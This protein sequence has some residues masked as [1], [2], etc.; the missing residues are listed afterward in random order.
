M[1][2]V[3]RSGFQCFRFIS[4]EPS[5]IGIVPHLPPLMT[6]SAHFTLN[7][8]LFSIC[9]KYLSPVLWLSDSITARKIQKAAKA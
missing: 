8:V 4:S 9:V 3:E 6:L 5:E 1:R 7:S 2:M